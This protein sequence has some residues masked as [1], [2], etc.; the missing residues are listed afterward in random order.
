MNVESLIVEIADQ[1][2]PTYKN[3]R[4]VHQM[5]SEIK[6]QQSNIISRLGHIEYLLQQIL[7]E[8]KK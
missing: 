8:K 4:N 1:M 6:E 7:L 2:D 5:V 3:V